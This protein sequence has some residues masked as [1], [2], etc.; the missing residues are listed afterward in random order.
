M[1]A[2]SPTGSDPTAEAAPARPT[3]PALAAVLAVGVGALVLGVLT[4]WAEASTGMHDFL[5]FDEDVGPL[6]GK[7]IIASVAF[8]A[9]W[10]LFAALWWRKSPPL[11][12]VL[13]TAAVLLA[14]GFL[15]TFPTFFQAFTSE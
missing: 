7:T 1:S 14:L 6:S 5:E 2:V 15:G 13:V 12:L 9:A 10:A 4:T 3:G 8:F 11:R